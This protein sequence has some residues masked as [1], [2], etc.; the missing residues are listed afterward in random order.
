MWG[1]VWLGGGVGFGNQ[2][3][4][5]SSIK[6]TNIMPNCFVEQKLSSIF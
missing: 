1:G 3:G 6:S 4:R 2:L 5:V